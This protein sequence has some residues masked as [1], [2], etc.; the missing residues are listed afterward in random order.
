M[1]R[2]SGLRILLFV[3]TMWLTNNSFGQS[4]TLTYADFLADPT[5]SS[6]AGV[7]E[8]TIRVWGAGGGGGGGDA[9]DEDD[10]AGGGGGGGYSYSATVAVVAEAPNAFCYRTGRSWRRIR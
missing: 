7:T 8:V 9:G 4:A 10:G 2:L 6:P 1:S 5:W 3:A